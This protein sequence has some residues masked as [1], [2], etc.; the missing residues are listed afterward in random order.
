MPVRLNF[1]VA[2]AAALVLFALSEPTIAAFGI[3]SVSGVTQTAA[4]AG[5][6]PGPGPLSAESA[7]PIIFPEVLGGTLGTPL[8]VDHDGSN[9][10]AVGPAV[11]NSVVNSAFVAAVLPQGTKYNSYLFHFDPLDESYPVYISTITFANPVIGVQIFSNGYATLQKP[12][13]TPYVGTLEAGDA[14]VGGSVVYPTG[15]DYRGL[16]E[17]GF[18][19]V[20]YNNKVSLIGIAMGGQI[21]QVRILTAVPEP[22]TFAV[23]G[24]ISLVCGCVVY[25]RRSS[26]GSL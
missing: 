24:L 5:V 21:D 12:L 10:V 2:T 14:A 4:P 8:P 22:T 20:V 17:D 13:N 19:L 3:T 25:Y 15:F 9:I 16:D 11:T 6:L 23:W 1:F 26:L 18:A 7:V